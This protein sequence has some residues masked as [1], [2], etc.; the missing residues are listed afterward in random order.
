MVDEHGDI[1]PLDAPSVLGAD[2]HGAVFR[3]DI[4][5]TV[6]GNVVVHPELQCLQ[7]SGLAMIAAAHDKGDALPDPH[8]GELAPVG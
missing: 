1:R 5:P 8:A 2:L 6:P 3:D 4:L 7:Q